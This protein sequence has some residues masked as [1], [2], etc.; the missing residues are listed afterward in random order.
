M[1][2]AGERLAEPGRADTG[3]FVGEGIPVLPVSQQLSLL[4]AFLSKKCAFPTGR[5][6]SQLFLCPKSTVFYFS[7]TLFVRRIQMLGILGC[8]SA[9]P[10]HG[11]CNRGTTAEVQFVGCVRAPGSLRVDT[12]EETDNKAV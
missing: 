6:K 2:V 10:T 3:V 5:K 9:R 12:S 4:Y 7:R 8:P 1:G 11:R